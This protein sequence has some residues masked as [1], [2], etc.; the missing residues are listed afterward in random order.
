[1]MTIGDLPEAKRPSKVILVG[2][3]Q[4]KLTSISDFFKKSNISTSIYVGDL[5]KPK[6][7]FRICREIKAA[8]A[9]IDIMG[10]NAGAWLTYKKREFQEDGFEKMYVVNFLQVRFA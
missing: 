10:L 5:Q 9:T 7:I 2:R 8:E 3:S 6:D 4:E 1:M